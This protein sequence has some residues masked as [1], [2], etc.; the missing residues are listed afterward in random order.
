MIEVTPKEGARNVVTVTVDGEYCFDLHTFVFGKNPSLPQHYT[1]I[2]EFTQQLQE[3]EHSRAKAFAY[4]K[5]AQKNLSSFEMVEIL[6]TH[7]ISNAVINHILDD[8]QRLGYINDEIWLESFTNGLISRKYGPDVICQK[9]VM[10]GVDRE[11]AKETIA[12]FFSAEDQQEKLKKLISTRYGR[13]DL[14][15]YKEKQKVIGALVR[16]GFHFQ[17]IISAMNLKNTDDF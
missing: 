9:L 14:S 11:E 17:E 16:K 15:I 8:C 4:K 10:K 5:L 6:K 13:R 3:I 2:E 7:L 12:K 1:S